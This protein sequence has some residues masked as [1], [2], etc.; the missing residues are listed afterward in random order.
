MNTPIRSKHLALASTA[1]AVAAITSSCKGRGEVVA[2]ESDLT[3]DTT[4]TDGNDTT[5]TEPTIEVIPTKRAD[6]LFDDFAF[7]FMQNRYFQKQRTDFPLPY[8]VDGEQRTINRN[9]WEY[10]RMYSQYELYTLIFDN[11][12]GEQAAKDTTLR[13]VTVEELD[14]A[15]RHTRS[16][17]F[18]RR[19]G[20]WRLTALCEGPM[21]QS[22]NSDFYNFYHHFA[23]DEEYQKEHIHTPLEFCTFDDDA[24]EMVEGIITPD[25]FADF[26]P[27]LPKNKITNI[28]Y[29]QSLDNSHVRVLSLR[30]LAGGME[31]TMTFKKGDDGEWRLTR[32]EN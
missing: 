9:E 25:Q 6:E 7:A 30:A 28:L 24:F 18:R 31:C 17:D 5:S 29:G 16:Y 4:L 10:D 13:Q 15:A 23:T 1:L 2:E 22:A 8:E 11:V 20:E 14:L 27:E 3:N 12:R 21:G 19:D 32:L 26:A